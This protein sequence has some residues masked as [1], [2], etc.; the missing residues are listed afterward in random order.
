MHWYNYVIILVKLVLQNTTLFHTFHREKSDKSSKHQFQL[1]KT[2]QW[3][4]AV[5]KR[6]SND[7]FGPFK[8]VKCYS[9]STPFDL[10]YDINIFS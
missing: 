10:P 9:E 4:I 3:S 5:L 7:N 6:K 1:Q 2:Q 8:T